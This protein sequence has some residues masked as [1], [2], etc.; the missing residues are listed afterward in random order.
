MAVNR[1]DSANSV[2]KQG[3]NFKTKIVMRVAQLQL[4]IKAKLQKSLQEFHPSNALQQKK[5]EDVQL[6]YWLFLFFISNF[7]IVHANQ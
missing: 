1:G 7:S 3:R 6:F 5:K 4:Q 2:N